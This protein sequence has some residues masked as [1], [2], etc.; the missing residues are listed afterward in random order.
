MLR[1][2]C[3]CHMCH[4]CH[5]AACYSPF[6]LGKRGSGNPGERCREAQGKAPLEE[7]TGNPSR[8]EARR[9]SSLGLESGHHAEIEEKRSIGSDTA[10]RQL[11]GLQIHPARRPSGSEPRLE[12][13]RRVSTDTGDPEAEG[14]PLCGPLGLLASPHGE[15]RLKAHNVLCAQ[16]CW[17]APGWGL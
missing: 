9:K 16:C 8:V 1:G 11:P 14:L 2:P 7:P 4:T 17:A 10:Q 13:G 5:A 12:S 3:A 6:Q 15:I